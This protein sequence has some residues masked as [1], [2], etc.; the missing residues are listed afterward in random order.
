M[1]HCR[2]DNIWE[3]ARNTAEAAWKCRPDSI[4]CQTQATQ[5]AKTL[6]T[7]VMGTPFLTRAFDMVVNHVTTCQYGRKTG[8]FSRKNRTRSGAYCG[9]CLPLMR[10]GRR[11]TDDVVSSREFLSAMP[12]VGESYL[13]LASQHPSATG[14]QVQIISVSVQSDYVP[15]LPWLSRKHGA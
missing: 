9:C 3:T 14:S 7:S 6:Y 1:C 10:D 11:A 12:L 8:S 15:S 13:D 2:L 5:R 4:D